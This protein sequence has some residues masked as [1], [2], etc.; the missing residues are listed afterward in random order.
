MASSGNL[1]YG[2]VWIAKLFELIN[3]EIMAQGTTYE[4]LLYLGSIAGSKVGS[5]QSYEFLLMRAQL[6]LYQHYLNILFINKKD[7]TTRIN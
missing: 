2:R 3:K 6:L 7:D 5:T 4:L 1:R